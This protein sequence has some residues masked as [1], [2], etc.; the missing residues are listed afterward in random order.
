M[1]TYILMRHTKIKMITPHRY[2]ESYT[3]QCKNMDAAQVKRRVMMSNK[4]NVMS[5]LWKW[6]NT[7]IF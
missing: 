7:G 3:K 1:G 5:K 2:R 4:C 6:N